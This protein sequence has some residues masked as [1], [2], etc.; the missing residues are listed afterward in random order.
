[1]AK[2]TLNSDTTAALQSLIGEAYHVP[3]GS[4]IVTG[5][6]G[7]ETVIVQYDYRAGDAI[8]TMFVISPD[9]VYVKVGCS[10]TADNTQMATR[11]EVDAAQATGEVSHIPVDHNATLAFIAAIDMSEIKRTHRGALNPDKV[12]EF[13][14]MMGVK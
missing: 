10:L 9:A 11:C 2:I 1:M 6:K 8:A 4:D 12:A 3:V 7:D 5:D 14:T 13:Q